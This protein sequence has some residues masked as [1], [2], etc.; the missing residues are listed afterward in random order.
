M[1]TGEGLD[2]RRS[3]ADGDE[4]GEVVGLAELRSLRLRAIAEGGDLSRVLRAEID[5]WSVE[6]LERLAARWVKRPIISVPQQP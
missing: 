6:G 3:G 4:D 1:E 2:P 5:H